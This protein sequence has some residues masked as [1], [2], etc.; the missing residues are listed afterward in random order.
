MAMP[1]PANPHV[2]GS[3]VPEDEMVGASPVIRFGPSP[4]SAGPIVTP[5]VPALMV[6]IPS[7]W[8]IPYSVPLR[9]TMAVIAVLES[10]LL[11]PTSVAPP[12]VVLIV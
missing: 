6:S 2:P 8:V 12:E 7:P 1:N 11:T 4:L 5:P 3:G 10:M 9:V